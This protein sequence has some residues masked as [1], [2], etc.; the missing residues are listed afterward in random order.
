MGRYERGTV[1]GRQVQEEIGNRGH[2]EF[3]DGKLSLLQ[4]CQITCPNKI[5]FETRERRLQCKKL[6]GEIYHK[7]VSQRAP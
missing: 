4:T 1:E 3:K 7:R 2:R 6:A 5:Q